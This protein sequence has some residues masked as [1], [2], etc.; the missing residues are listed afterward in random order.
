VEL[1]Q[2]EKISA[3]N[4]EMSEIYQEK[5]PG[6]FQEEYQSYIYE[7]LVKK[8]LSNVME[9]FPLKTLNLFS[10]VLRFSINF[11]LKQKNSDVIEDLSLIWRKFVEKKPL[12]K[13]FRNVLVDVIKNIISYIGENKKELFPKM[14]KELRKFKYL[15][16]RRL[17]F[18]SYYN[19]SDIS[20]DIVSNLEIDHEQ[21]RSIDKNYE[22]FHFFETSF[23]KLPKLTQENYKKF[24]NK[25]VKKERKKWKKR[26]WK[27]FKWTKVYPDLTKERINKFVKNWQIEK[28]KAIENFIDQDFLD[29]LEITREEIERVNLFRESEITFGTKSPI[30]KDKIEKM[31][32]DEISSFLLS[33]ESKKDF[34]LSKIGLGRELEENV[35]QRPDDFIIMLESVLKNNK[36]HK[37]ISFII[38]GL[39]KALKGE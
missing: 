21:F 16:F 1:K 26:K 30:S 20:G 12:S 36:L 10:N 28:L 35:P 2:F 7:D 22:L 39:N 18:M 23:D 5:L 31:T 15:I 34:N 27:K 14:I 4:Y 37:Y 24:V 3:K 19:F 32:M 11:F 9:K 17:E 13:N 8:V 25:E 38:R 29:N 6:E 33:Y